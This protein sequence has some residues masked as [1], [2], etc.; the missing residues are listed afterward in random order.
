MRK[1]KRKLIIYLLLFGCLLACVPPTE[2]PSSLTPTMGWSS[3]N[4]F[5]H[6]VTAELVKSQAD[7]MV[8]T[9]LKDVGYCYINTDDGYFGGRDS[10]DG[11]LL[12]HTEKFPDGLRP[13]VDYIHNLGLKAG[14]YSDAGANTCGAIWAGNTSGENCGLYGHDEQDLTLF[15]RDLGFDF[16][17][18]DYCG[19]YKQQAT[20]EIIHARDR[21][22]AISEAIDTLAPE[23][24]RM[25]VCTG[26]F[27]GAWAAG[28]AGSWRATSDIYCSWPSVSGIISQCL[29]LSA[30]ASPGHYNDMD[31]LEVGRG[32]TPEEDKT[33]FGLWCI[34]NSPLLIGCDLRTLSDETLALLSNRDLIALNQDPLCRPAYLAA[35]CDGCFVLVKDVEKAHGPHRAVAIYNPSDAEVHTVLR[36]ID[37]DL[38]GKVAVRDLFIQQPLGT[39]S[40]SLAVSLPAHGT[41]IFR[42]DA[43]RRQERVRYEA[44]TALNPSYQRMYNYQSVGSGLYT[45]DTACSTGLKANWLGENADNCLIWDDVWSRHGGDYTLTFR[46]L[47]AEDRQ[48]DVE[49]NGRKVSTLTANSGAWNQWTTV[50][51]PVHLKP[52]TNTIR[53]ANAEAFMPDVDYMMIMKNDK[54]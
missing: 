12:I 54:P 35:Q 36:F 50:S 27:P 31:M 39:Y 48:F 37:V 38:D 2:V 10:L 5:A 11:H 24:V 19:G 15:F 49:V 45:Y 52:Q 16:L 25:N 32:L 29:Y 17:K 30:F 47:S 13:V 4:T 22:T 34:M 42:L 14:I 21:Y 43:K 9:G 8:A 23:G 26:A 40:D 20:G 18:V 1:M 53:I 28:V 6:D 41:R 44:E 3:W 51:L 7:A 46:V 33:H